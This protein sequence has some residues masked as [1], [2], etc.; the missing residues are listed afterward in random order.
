MQHVSVYTHCLF[1][2]YKQQTQE[3]PKLALQY[4]WKRCQLRWWR[5]P[6]V[7]AGRCN[8]NCLEVCNV[9]HVWRRFD[10]NNNTLSCTTHMM[11]RYMDDDNAAQPAPAQGGGGMQP[12][13]E[14]RYGVRRGSEDS[15]M[16][17]EEE[18]E[19]IVDH[20]Q[21]GGVVQYRV[22]WLGRGASDDEW[23][24][25]DEMVEASSQIAAL[26]AEYEA[27]VSIRRSP[28][29][30]DKAPPAQLQRPPAGG[31]GGAM[32]SARSL[33]SSTASSRPSRRGTLH[34]RRSTA[35]QVI[36]ASPRR[37]QSPSSRGMRRR[38]PAPK[39]PL[40]PA[41]LGGR[42]LGSK[43]ATPAFTANAAAE[44]RIGG[45]SDE[46]TEHDGKLFAVPL[47]CCCHI[48]TV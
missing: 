6:S 10:F 22:R 29:R 35:T 21:A 17:E 18:V 37:R 5:R 47:W 7:Q 15:R 48:L 28:R 25:R 20:R 2:L 16:T 13:Q 30:A 9:Y 44:P 32:P 42:V 45:T 39:S 11:E 40:Y 23:F 36:H 12:H 8:L 46:V 38:S 33:S 24:D 43:Q 26:V 19:A 3:E 31:G 34:R 14:Q 4:M 41:R 27:G 1:T